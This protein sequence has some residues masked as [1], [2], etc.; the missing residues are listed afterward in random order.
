MLSSQAWPRPK[1][2]YYGGI[3][4]YQWLARPLALHGVVIRENG[5]SLA[6][7]IGEKPGE[8]VFCIADLLPHLAET[9]QPDHQRRHLR[10]KS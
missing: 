3:R 8:P 6:V 5:E 10:P 2:H 4:K 1:T 9:E 7:S